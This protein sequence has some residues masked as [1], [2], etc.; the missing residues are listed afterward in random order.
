MINDKG[1][2]KTT[3]LLEEKTQKD[4]NI[5]FSLAITRFR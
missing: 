5:A 2:H 3:C 1:E 4:K